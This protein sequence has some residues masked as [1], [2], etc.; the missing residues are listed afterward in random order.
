M[1]YGR[2]Y[3]SNESVLKPVGTKK[4]ESSKLKRSDR[5]EGLADRR[6]VPVI[7]RQF[8]PGIW[9]ED[10]DRVCTTSQIA[11]QSKYTKRSL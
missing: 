4:G 6:C 11:E 7:S 2:G 5:R 3:K 9:E 1:K 10:V 8:G